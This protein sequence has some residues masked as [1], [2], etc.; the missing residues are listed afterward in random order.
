MRSNVGEM[1]ILLQEREF[2]LNAKHTDI[3]NKG[4]EISL[5]KEQLISRIKEENGLYEENEFL[6]RQLDSA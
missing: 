3:E 6:R 2:A 4:R 5:L 1:E